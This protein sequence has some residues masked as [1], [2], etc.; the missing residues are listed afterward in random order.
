MPSPVPDSP[1]HRGA[2]P[3]NTN[4]A[5]P[6]GEKVFGVGRV[7]ADFGPLKSKCVKAAS[8]EG[9]TLTDWLKEAAEEKLGRESTASG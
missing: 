1:K 5:K 6:E 2:Q 9:K 3:G 4:A 8:R 7:I